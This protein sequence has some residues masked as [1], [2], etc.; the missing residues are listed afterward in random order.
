MSSTLLALLALIE[1]ALGEFPQL[2]ADIESLIAKVKGNSVATP[3]PP[4]LAPQIEAQDKA[5]LDELSKPV[6]S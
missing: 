3:P 4:P 2:L 6:G 5:V 1:S